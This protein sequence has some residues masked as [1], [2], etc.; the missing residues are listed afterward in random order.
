MP[1][2]IDQIEQIV[3]DEEQESIGFSGEGSVIQSNRATLLNYYNQKPYGDEQE[4]MSQVVTSDV[5]DQV[6]AMQPELIRRFTQAKHIARFRCREEEESNQK[7]EYA[8][9]VFNA[10]NDAVQ[11]LGDMFFDGNLQYN[12]VVKVAWDDSKELSEKNWTGLDQIDLLRLQSDASLEIKEIEQDEETGLFDV[13]AEKVISSG[14]HEITNIP[15]NELLI[16][17]RARD[18][19]DPP[20]IGQRT[21]KTRSDLIQMGLP[22]DKV[23]SLSKESDDIDDEVKNARNKDLHSPTEENPTSDPSKDIIY[24]GEYYVKIDVDQDGISELWQVFFADNQVLEMTRVDDHPYCVHVPIPMPHK[25]I[26]TCIAEQVADKQYWKSTLVRQANNNVYATNFN[27]VVTN[28]RTKLDDLLTPRH[29]GVVRVSGND[30]VQNSVMPM[31]VQNQVPAVLQMI[32]YVDAAIEKQTGITSYNQGV[33]TESL[34]KTAYGFRGIRDM[35]QMRIEL[36]S[37][38]A[39]SGAVKRIFQKIIELA[40]IHVED[41]VVFTNGKKT[42][43]ITPSQWSE[44]AECYIDVGLGSGDRQEKI[45]NLNMLY[46][47][48]KELKATGSPLVDDKKMYSTLDK[49]TM[50]VGLKGADSYFNDPSQPNELLKAEN[51][52]L[53]FMIQEMQAQLENPLTEAEQIRAD[54]KI[55]ET[56]MKE[57]NKAQIEAAKLEQKERHHDDEMAVKLTDIET[58]QKIN[59]PGSLV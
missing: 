49:I 9:W 16:A 40:E 20:F 39:A 31:P 35:S 42:F 55:Q 24:L 56:F 21:P 36:V 12:G 38:I 2:S 22:K 30:A 14:R 17:R 25:A 18:F 7:T 44:N 47:E 3:R 11:I 6:N 46:S 26:G 59:V 45:A 41:T 27:R 50:E 23:L 28:E 33:D 1:L 52:Q 32:E 53:R 34:N 51:E 54:S 48:Q 19:I 29:G 4:G 5:A 10:Q 37:R 13:S 58:K 57:Q 43:E 8:S 15:P